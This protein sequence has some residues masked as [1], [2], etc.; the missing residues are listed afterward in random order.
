MARGWFNLGEHM[1]SATQRMGRTNAKTDGT[2]DLIAEPIERQLT[3]LRILRHFAAWRSSN[4]DSPAGDGLQVRSQGT[5]SV[6]LSVTI[7]GY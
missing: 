6:S 2:R 4:F 5:L 7:P 1:G 3:V